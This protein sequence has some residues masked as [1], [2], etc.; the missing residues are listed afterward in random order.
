MEYINEPILI[1]FVSLLAGI[2]IGC[3][4]TFFI[5]NKDIRETEGELQIV[6]Q[7]YLDEIYVNSVID[8]KSIKTRKELEEKIEISKQNYI[9][10]NIKQKFK[11]PDLKKVNKDK[12]SFKIKKPSKNRM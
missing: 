7:L 3:V 5:L 4:I 1:I 12:E 11:K 9:R 10:D 2:L 8:Q 6:N